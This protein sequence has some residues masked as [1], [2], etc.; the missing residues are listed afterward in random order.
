MR[1]TTLKQ[2][3]KRAMKRHRRLCRWE[4]RRDKENNLHKELLTSISPFISSC[5][6]SIHAMFNAILSLTLTANTAV[7][8]V[9]IIDKRVSNL[10]FSIFILSIVLYFFSV[11]SIVKLKND[12]FKNIYSKVYVYKKYT[13]DYI[14]YTKI[15]IKLLMATFIASFI[16]F[17]YGIFMYLD[18]K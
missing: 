12:I 17:S 6:G 10:F 16:S 13:D 3:N 11:M 1:A 2:T 9:L 4:V 7:A 5:D 8:C 15:N 14:V 18:V